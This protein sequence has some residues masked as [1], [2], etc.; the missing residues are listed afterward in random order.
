MLIQGL[1]KEACDFLVSLFCVIYLFMLFQFCFFRAAVA[2]NLA[3]IYVSLCVV[4]RVVFV[5]HFPA[6]GVLAQK[7]HINNLIINTPCIVFVKIREKVV[8]PMFILIFHDTIVFYVFNNYI[9]KFIVIRGNF[10]EAHRFVIK[11]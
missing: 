2:P 8:N 7:L 9:N 4:L 3:Y 6:L 5:Q 11:I 1:K 10:S